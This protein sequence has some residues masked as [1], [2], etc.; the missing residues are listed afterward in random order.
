M[1]RPPSSRSYRQ[2]R[3]LASTDFRNA[4]FTEQRALDAFELPVLTFCPLGPTIICPHDN[5]FVYVDNEVAHSCSV[6]NGEIVNTTTGYPL[7][8]RSQARN[9][10]LFEQRL[11]PLL[12]TI[13]A[14]HKFT[15]FSDLYPDLYPQLPERIRTLSDRV[16]KLY[17]LMMWKPD[18]YFF[19]AD[20]T[21]I[22]P[23]FPADLSL[24]NPSTR[25]Q[26]DTAMSV[27]A[28]SSSHRRQLEAGDEYSDSESEDS[29]DSEESGTSLAASEVNAALANLGSSNQDE[30]V[31][32]FAAL[33]QQTSGLSRLSKP[34]NKRAN[35]AG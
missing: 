18:S 28:L 19:T 6:V 14:Y 11:S 12:C 9:T 20:V 23:P 27:P 8:H 13:N 30:R 5:F 3:Q 2:R 24:A 29:W 17:G 15:R 1:G 22:A 34:L 10:P 32:A 21:V 31:A 4:D 35:W 25:R 26:R 16:R 7:P 33:T